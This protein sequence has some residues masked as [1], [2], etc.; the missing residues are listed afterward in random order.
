MKNYIIEQSHRLIVETAKYHESLRKQNV[1]SFEELISYPFGRIGE[2]FLMFS[3]LVIAFGAMLAYTIVVKDTVPTVLGYGIENEGSG[4]ERNLIVVIVW[5]FALVP[6]TMLKDLSSLEY[7]SAISIFVSLLLVVLIIAESPILESLEA[8]GGLWE[9]MKQHWGRPNIFAAVNILNEAIAWQHGALIMF[10]SLRGANRRRWF[11]V[12]TFVN[13]SA[14]VLYALVGIP[15]W[16]GFLEETQGNI[17]NNFAADSVRTNVARSFFAVIMVLTYPLEALIAR[18][19]VEVLLH[20]NDKESDSNQGDGAR[21]QSDGIGNRGFFETYFLSKEQM[22]IALLL[23]VVALVTSLILNDLGIVLQM[24]GALGGN[25]LCFIAPGIIYLGVHGRDFILYSN[26]LLGCESTPTTTTNFTGFMDE[27][28]NVTSFFTSSNTAAYFEEVALSSNDKPFWW[29]L[30]GFPLWCY[31]ASYGHSHMKE[32]LM[33]SDSDTCSLS[34]FMPIEMVLSDVVS[35]QVPSSSDGVEYLEMSD[36]KNQEEKVVPAT[37][38]GFFFAI[39]L[40]VFGMVSLVAGLV[41]V[42][43]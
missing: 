13:V 38:G 10:G 1:S 19:V 28:T 42:P 40:V 26:G 3:M 39:F 15:G 29:Y 18:E 31:I 5:V 9:I 30:L 20:R 23:N 11:F 4:M 34:S 22:L 35:H 33:D 2:Y 36:G 6:L 24:V 14:C 43:E 7:T 8:N 21:G 12:T 41:F 27:P 37:P 32:R 17:L 25:I 16:I